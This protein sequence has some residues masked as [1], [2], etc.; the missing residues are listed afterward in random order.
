M[1]CKWCNK[2]M[3]GSDGDGI[4][5]ICLNKTLYPELANLEPLYT[6]GDVETYG[7]GILRVDY[8]DGIQTGGRLERL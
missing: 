6:V 8:K 4:C 5:V 3:P 7:Y 1:I 2:P